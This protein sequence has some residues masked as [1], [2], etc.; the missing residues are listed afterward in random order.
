VRYETS[1]STA[2]FEMVNCS[3]SQRGRRDSGSGVH[4]P[5]QASADF[6]CDAIHGA[7]QHLDHPARLHSRIARNGSHSGDIHGATHCAIY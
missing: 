2:I 3:G 5:L 7:S 1:N 4:R 6:T